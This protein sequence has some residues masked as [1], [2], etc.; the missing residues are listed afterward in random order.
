M[1]MES[2]SQSVVSVG[3]ILNNDTATG[4]IRCELNNRR[5]FHLRRGRSHE[6]VAITLSVGEHLLDTCEYIL[7]TLIGYNVFTLP[8][9]E[10]LLDTCEYILD[11]LITRFV[12]IEMQ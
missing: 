2:Y 3:W 4:G 1:S 7:D 10:Y 5:F 12:S 9:G 6:C 8:A 11:T